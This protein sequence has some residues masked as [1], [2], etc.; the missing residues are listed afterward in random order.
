M[1]CAVF[2]LSGTMGNQIAIRS[3]LKQPPYSV[4]CNRQSHLFQYECGTVSAFSQA[5]MIPVIPKNSAHMSLEDIIP[6]VVPDDGDT[7][8]SPKRVISIENT[9]GG[10]T[11]PL[12]EVGR[13]SNYARAK[14]ISLHIDGARLWNAC[15]QSEAPMTA[16]QAAEG[17]RRLLKSYC[18]LAN[19]VSLCLSKSL[20]AP[21][22]SVLAC[23][24]P[25]LASRA[26]HFRKAM[27]GGMRQIGVLTA[28]GRVAIESVFLSGEHLPRANAI[29][30]RLEDTWK[31]L[32]GQV[33][34]GLDQE[35]NMVWLDLDGMGIT[36]E[37][38]V[39]IV[40][41]YGVKVSDGRIVTHY[42]ESIS[43]SRHSPSPPS[44]YNMLRTRLLNHIIASEI[45]DDAVTALEDA[46][47]TVA[48]TGQGGRRQRPSKQVEGEKATP[49]S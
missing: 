9:I 1:R 41:P 4:I 24:S 26:R 5:Q 29:A 18:S 44:R 30:K 14:G 27:G 32:G 20:G 15:Y 38:F 34:P 48:E 8:C 36:D 22:G 31:S 45:T 6:N 28:P 12:E 3:L 43:G 10:R 21:G 49:L 19:T 46:L 42:R 23:N 35:T 33:Q 16:S 25:D 37:E 39:R 13:I 2:V 17:A 11:V 7:H 47:R 40:T